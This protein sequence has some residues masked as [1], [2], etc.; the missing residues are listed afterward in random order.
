MTQ[1]DVDDEALAEVLRRSG[2]ATK[3]DAV[4]EALR[5]YAATL[6]RAA[7]FDGY[8][9]RAQGWDYEGWKEL[10]AQDKAWY[11]LSGPPATTGPGHD[12]PGSAAD[13]GPDWSHGESDQRPV[14]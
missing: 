12:R 11:P 2:L 7:G 6:R 3:S 1:I 8:I 9:Q 10:R 4:N 5:H 13:A 14:Q